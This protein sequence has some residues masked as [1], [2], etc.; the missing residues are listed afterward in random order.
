MPFEGMQDDSA[1]SNDATQM[2]TIGDSG[3]PQVVSSIETIV[4]QISTSWHGDDANSFV[5]E[6]NSTFKPNL[7]RIASEISQH[8]QLALTNVAAQQ[9]ASSGTSIA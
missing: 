7:V 6:W 9:A 4:S 3:I 8:G 5:N 1:V 2:K